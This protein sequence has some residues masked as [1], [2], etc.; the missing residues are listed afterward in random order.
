M[1]DT[2][3][4]KLA[5]NLIHFS[6]AVAPGERVLIE[7]IGP[8]EELVRALV[9][10]T[11]AAQALPFV[12]LRR[13]D[14]NRELALGATAPQLDLRARF[15]GDMMAQMQAYIG[16][17]GGDNS[18]EM[19][20]VPAEKLALTAARYNE[21]V[22][23]KIRVPKT[24]WVVLRYPTPGMAQQ[25]NMSTAGFEEYYFNVCNLDYSKM[26]AAMD[27]LQALMERTDKVHIVGPGTDLRFSIKGMPAIKCAG[28]MNIPDGEI[29]TAPVTGSIEG[30]LA[31]NTPSVLEG[32]TYENIRFHFE[33]GRIVK[34]CCND[35]ARIEQ[36]LNRDAGARGVG[37]F[38]LGVNPYITAPMKDTLFDE[39]IAGSFHFTPGCCYDE[40]DNGNKSALHWDLVCIQTPEYGGG[41]IYFDDVLVRSDGRFVLPELQCLNPENLV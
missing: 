21:P 29:F 35:D 27:A 18:T 28:H 7:G 12:W 24:K 23:S 6:C 30:K 38:A 9:R 40:C 37:E 11:Y 13:P 5:H 17:R 20:D 22:H 4:Q 25:A 2:R 36:V 1:T 39:K 31:Y 26:D 10:E 14:I 16:V 19:S 34:A 15:E 8:V 32:F 41:E 33:K 3:I